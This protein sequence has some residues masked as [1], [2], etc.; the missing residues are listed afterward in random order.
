M[1]YF[2]CTGS[3]TISGNLSDLPS[4]VATFYCAGYNTISGNLSGLPSG[5]TYFRCTGSNT[6]SGNLSDLP[7][8]LTFFLCYG[9]NTISGDLSS[10]PSG[11]YYFNCAGSN[12]ISDY[13]SKVWTTKPST[14]YFEPT[15]VGGLS[16]AE[17]DQLLID[18]DDDLVWAAGN[19]ITLTGTNA[20][21][22]SASDAAVANMVAE[23]ATVT[24]N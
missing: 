20:A 16:T 13:T 7:S 6:I 11:V 19:T 21:R 1:I 22:S 10:L 2:E 18:F 24:T 4:G 14:F 15:G 5:M 3:N 17:I 9:S 8:G 12:T 23:G